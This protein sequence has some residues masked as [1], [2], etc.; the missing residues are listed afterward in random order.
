MTEFGDIFASGLTIAVYVYGSVIML[1]GYGL[2]VLSL[3]RPAPVAAAPQQA[4]GLS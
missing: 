4:F 3:R 1:A 2:F